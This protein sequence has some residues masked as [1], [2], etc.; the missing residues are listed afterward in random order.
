MRGI[1]C[2]TADFFPRLICLGV[3][4]A[5]MT[6]THHSGPGVTDDTEADEDPEQSRSDIDPDDDVYEVETLFKTLGQ[7]KRMDVNIRIIQ[8]EED[9]DPCF[10]Y[11]KLEV[12]RDNICSFL[13]LFAFD[14]VF[15]S[16][17]LTLI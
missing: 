14:T 16:N 15:K 10:Y 11:S 13:F 6:V 3:Q 7:R 17:Q 8:S 5:K 9:E 1:Y 4:V 2:Y 12:T